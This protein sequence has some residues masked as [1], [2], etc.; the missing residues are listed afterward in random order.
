MKPFV[1][2]SIFLLVVVIWSTTPLAI[3]LSNQDFGFALAV[4]ARMTLGA[5]LVWLILLLR[6][7]SL[8]SSASDWRVYAIASIG[9]FPNMPLVYWGAQFIPSGLLSLVF[10][11]VPFFMGMFGKFILGERLGQNRIIGLMV[12]FCGLSVVFWDQLQLNDEAGKGIGAVILSTLL[13][14]I[15][16][17]WIKKIGA[18]ISPL[19]QACGSM[20]FALPGLWLCWWL[21]GASW[22]SSVGIVPASAGMYLVIMGSVIGFS[23]YYFLLRHLQASTTALI[24]MLSP[25]LA[26]GLGVA[27]AEESFSTHYFVGTGLVLL[28]LSV[29]SGI[30]KAILK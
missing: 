15:S 9:V 21:L 11:S 16:S 10:S 13:F 22:P 19:Q 7:Q 8:F 28:G 4:S 29:Y 26:M 18:E 17:V 5:S 27:V 2:P 14:S 23:A 3:Q 30:G 20:L 1:V 6:G 25:I 12:A 24:S